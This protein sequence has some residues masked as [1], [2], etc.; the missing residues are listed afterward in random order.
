MSE[1]TL[2]GS[3]DISYRECQNEIPCVVVN[4]V[5]EGCLKG[6]L[7]DLVRAHPNWGLPRLFWI[8]MIVVEHYSSTVDHV[9]SSTLNE[10][11][12]LL[13]RPFQLHIENNLASFS[14]HLPNSSC[15]RVCAGTV[16]S[17]R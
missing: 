10:R 2:L 3:D 9:P 16:L 6:N 7:C 11:R 8:Q 13:S 12:V 15:S 4:E 17:T 5:K 1:G 14:I